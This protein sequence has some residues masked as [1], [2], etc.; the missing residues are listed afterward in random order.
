[1]KDYLKGSLSDEEKRYIYGIINKTVLKYFRKSDNKL[2][3][4]SISINDNNFPEKL[5][6]RN[7]KYNLVNKILETKILRDIYALK[8]YSKYGKEKIV[9]ALEKV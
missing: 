3:K 6:A 1:M 2:E 5:L 7:D 4:E 9:E 8:P